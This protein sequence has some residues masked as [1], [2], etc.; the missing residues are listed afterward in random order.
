MHPFAA[1]FYDS[2]QLCVQKIQ[3][4][5]SPKRYAVRDLFDLD[6]LLSSTLSKPVA[7]KKL[8]GRG[9]VEKAAEKTDKFHYD[10]FKEQVLPYLPD[11]LMTLYSN[12]TAFGGLKK[13]V[14]DHLLEM[15][16]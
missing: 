12:S 14:E 6:H 7:I 4:L 10:D 16:G 15:M 8:I 9:D 11:S 2:D 1:R 13:R 5:S 3:A